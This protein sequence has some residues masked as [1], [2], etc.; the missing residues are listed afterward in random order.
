MVRLARVAGAHAMTQS[1]T[2]VRDLVGTLWQEG[3][4]RI[5]LLTA[6]FSGISV[7][8]LVIGLLIPKRYDTFALVAVG[9]GAAMKPLT[10]GG[11]LPV[12]T[13]DHAAITLQITEGKKIL[14]ELLVFGGWEEA[15]KQPDPLEEAKLL[16]KLRSR[17]RIDPPKEGIVRVSYYDS[18]PARTYKMANKIAEIY[19]RESEESQVRDSREAFDFIDQQAKEYSEKLSTAHA[20]VLARYGGELPPAAGASSAHPA[21]PPRPA[22]AAGAAV[23]AQELTA[24]RAEKTTL[25]AQLAPKTPSAP[26]QPAGPDPAIAARVKQ[27]QTELDQLSAKYTDQHPDVKRVTRELAAAKEEQ[28][29]SE[30]ARAA[31]E[32][33]AEQNTAALDDELTTAARARLKEVNQR[34]AAAT[35]VAYVPPPRTSAHAGTA[36]QRDPELRGIGGDTKLSELVRRYEATRDVY[37]DLLKRRETARVAMEM[38]TEHRGL[39]LRIQEAAEFPVVATGLRLSHFC[40]VGIVLG[41]LIP[42]GVLFAIVRLDGRVRNAHEIEILAKVPLLVSISA[43]PGAKEKS[44]LKTQ[45]SLAALL[46]VGVAVIYVATFIIKTR[47][48]S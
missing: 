16:T 31:A 11:R 27:L 28:Q 39:N 8:A 46:L 35:G 48:S 2:Y 30:V 24:L 37:Q 22:P 1:S 47:M 12:G 19:I 26:A 25:E 21:P 40:M 44:K 4:R 5:L 14:R 3:K 23:S 10:E 18:D 36:D 34:I 20:A 42:L 41:A 29:R 13:V 17:M 9:S 32:K 6:I 7:A 38:S 43:A 45:K 15:G 33:V